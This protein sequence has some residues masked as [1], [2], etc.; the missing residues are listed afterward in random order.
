MTTPIMSEADSRVLY[1]SFWGE[2]SW[3]RPNP[4]SGINPGRASS[5]GSAASAPSGRGSGRSASSSAVARS[6]SATAPATG[7]GNARVTTDLDMSI[8]DIPEYEPLDLSGIK[9]DPASPDLQDLS[10]ADTALG[11]MEDMIGGLRE[12]NK[13]WMAGKVSGDT[14][15]QLRSQAALSARM[16]GAGVDSQMSRNLQ[17]RDFGLTSMQIQEAGMQRESQLTQLQQALAGM[18]EQRMQFM[19]QLREE[20][21]RYRGAFEMDKAKVGEASRQF[22]ANLQDQM[23]RTQLAHK[24]LMLKQEAFNAEQ[25]MRLVELIS[26]STLGFL[27]LQV[28]AAGQETDFGGGVKTYETLQKQLEGLWS[29]SNP[30]T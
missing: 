28:Q 1:E 25:N 10:K 8:P 19:T 17:A 22:G 20:Q 11:A 27:Q 2:G 9:Y 21:E 12:K 6:D 4:V 13:D 3:N 16:G 18:R 15:D 24:E 14:A 5:T 7:A 23:Y 29:R 30:K 26:Q